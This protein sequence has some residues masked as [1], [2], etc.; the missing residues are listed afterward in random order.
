M[1]DITATN[2]S[3]ST[4]DDKMISNSYRYIL[5]LLEDLPPES[6]AM[7]EQF[8]LFLHKQGPILTNFSEF[9]LIE[10]EGTL[11]ITPGRP[12]VSELNPD[13]Q[14]TETELDMESMFQALRQEREKY[15]AEKYGDL[16]GQT[17]HLR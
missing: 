6:L 10:L 17:P 4:D 9:H 15:V 11:I 12:V 5:S 16:D 2:N 13:I 7:V 14:T 8:V 3:N 1:V